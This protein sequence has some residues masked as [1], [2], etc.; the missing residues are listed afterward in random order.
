MMDSG[1]Q[2]SCHFHSFSVINPVILSYSCIWPEPQKLLCKDKTWPH[3]PSWAIIYIQRSPW[4]CEIWCNQRDITCV[5]SNKSMA[6]TICLSN[7]FS[8][9]PRMLWASIITQSAMRRF[10]KQCIK[11]QFF[12]CGSL[13][14][15]TTPVFWLF[16]NDNCGH[17]EFS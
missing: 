12:E 6:R 15:S 8:H 3:Q 13:M 10:I 7:G 1:V 9:G 14:T 4:V 5:N 11:Y 2:K 16:E 17:M